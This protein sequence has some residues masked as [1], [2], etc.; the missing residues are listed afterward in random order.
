ML[1]SSSP[2]V[3]ALCLALLTTLLP[4]SLAHW[5]QDQDSIPQRPL[6]K[7]PIKDIP[8]V[9]LGL[10]NSKDEDASKAVEYAFETGYRHLDSAAAYGNEAFVGRTLSNSS[11]SPAR[12]SYWITSKL[13]N[14]AHQPKHVRPALEQTLRD[15]RVPYLDLYLMHWPVA[16]LPGQKPGRT[17]IDQ[18]TS[19]HDTW[20]A[21]E[22]LVAANL[23]RRI[24]VSNFSPRQ[25][26]ELLAKCKVRP[27]AHEFETHPYLQ[28]QEFVDWHRR[29]NITVVAYSPLANSNP[30]YDG[31]YPDLP[32]I[33]EDPFW[34]DLAATKNV[35]PAQAILAWGRQRGTIV[36]PKSVHQDRIEENLGSLKISFTDEEML[37]IAEQDKRSRFNNPSKSW[38]VELFEGLDDGSSRFMMNEE[39]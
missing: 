30:T 28:Q 3:V 9:G 6:S 12:E 13:W 31:K 19:I 39:L 14:T 16:F 1:P 21:M 4:A 20:A 24:G 22:A 10:W 37:K 26:D 8:Q 18:D 33:L 2:H 7:G 11:L 32:P 27:W 25:L 35:T 38:G 23:T 5:D 17:V 34:T 15:L 36:I 29:N